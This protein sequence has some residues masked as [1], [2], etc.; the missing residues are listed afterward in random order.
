MPSGEYLYYVNGSNYYL[1]IAGAMGFPGLLLLMYTFACILKAG[2][3]ASF[4]VGEELYQ[5]ISLGIMAGFVAMGIVLVF[6]PSLVHFPVGAYLGVGAAL[7][8]Q[9]GHR[10]KKEIL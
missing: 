4:M 8:F 3:K 10:F 7:I 2:F 6:F 1:N 5:G 9:I